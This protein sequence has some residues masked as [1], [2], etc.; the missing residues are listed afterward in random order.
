MKSLWAVP[1]VL[2]NKDSKIVS[3]DPCYRDVRYAPNLTEISI[4][5][6][7]MDFVLFQ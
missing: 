1:R 6:W 2:Q 7:S 3:P 5:I 4:M